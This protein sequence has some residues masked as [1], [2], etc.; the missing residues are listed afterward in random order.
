MALRFFGLDPSYALTGS[1]PL[2]RCYFVDEVTGVPTDPDSV[3]SLEVYLGGVLQRSFIPPDITSPG[4]G[5]YQ[6]QDVVLDDPAVL[7][8]RWTFID[9]GVTRQASVSF[10][11]VGTVYGTGDVKIRDYVLTQLGDGV[12]WVGLPAHTFDI[13]LRKAKTWYAMRKGQKRRTSFN[14]LPSQGIYVM[15]DDCFYVTNVYFEGQRTQT[16]E[17][18]GAFGI[19]GFTQ[20][21]LSNIPAADLYGKGG[22]QGTYSSLVQSLQYA[23]MGRR[24]LNGDPSWEWREDD[25]ELWIFPVP[26]RSLKV[27]VDYSSS[28]VNTDNMNPTEEY[29]LMEYTLAECKQALGV[30]RRKFSGYATAQGERSLD[31]DSLTAEAVE[32]KRQLDEEI[33]QMAGAGWIITG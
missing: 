20:L 1:A 23:D 18:L 9:G 8:L 22:A 27:F 21:G 5:L 33:K 10:E 31:G 3:L 2:Y 29:Y 26:D 11:V 17:A 15:P 32:M 6:A 28:R 24:V 16:T 19:W 13:A 4:V 7:E 12:M 25:R 14:L 30:I